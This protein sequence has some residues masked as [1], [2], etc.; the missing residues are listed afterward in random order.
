MIYLHPDRLLVDFRLKLQK[1][2]SY[3]S[4]EL[5]ESIQSTFVS[6]RWTVSIYCSEIS[7]SSKKSD[8]RHHPVTL[9]LT[10]YDSTWNLSQKNCSNKVR[11][12]FKL[13]NTELSVPSVW[14]SMAAVHSSNT[15]DRHE[16]TV[17]VVIAKELQH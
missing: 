6:G 7:F 14:C 11:R 5:Q 4:A 17:H 9:L 1:S 13:L 10:T 15:Q 2:C 16:W 12:Y 8:Q 3:F